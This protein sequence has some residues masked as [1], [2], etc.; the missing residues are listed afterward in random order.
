MKQ[1][2][3]IPDSVLTHESQQRIITG[4]V[5]AVVVAIGMVAGLLVVGNQEVSALTNQVT[6]TET[7]AVTQ[8]VSTPVTDSDTVARV[9]QLNTLSTTDIQ[10]LTAFN[11][12]STLTPQE[13]KLTSYSYATTTSGV[14]LKL[15]G[16][17]PSNVSFAAF[18]ES[19]QQNSTLTTPKVDAYSYLPTTGVVTFVVSAVV[20]RGK[21]AYP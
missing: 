16:T 7:K 9:S 17:A 2:N 13:V 10:W 3:F 12:V 6:A 1:I 15:A 14:T 19:I 11:L 5:S 21:L 4:V 20:P 8:V 18:V